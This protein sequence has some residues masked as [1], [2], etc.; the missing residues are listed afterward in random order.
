MIRP[1]CSRL[2]FLC[3][4]FMNSVDL[5]EVFQIRMKI[6][7]IGNKDKDKDMVIDVKEEFE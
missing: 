3:A 2:V 5:K 1:A 7:R 4:F 6:G